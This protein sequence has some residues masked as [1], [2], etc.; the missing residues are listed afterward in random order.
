MGFGGDQSNLRI[1]YNND[2]VVMT[3]FVQREEETYRESGLQTHYSD[4]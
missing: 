4:H 2:I 3:H 1:R